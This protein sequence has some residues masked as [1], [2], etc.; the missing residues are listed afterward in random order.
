MKDTSSNRTLTISKLF[1]LMVPCQFVVGFSFRNGYQD[2]I[3]GYDKGYS[4]MSF[5]CFGVAGLRMLIVG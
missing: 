2:C 4:A 1:N 5:L 3:T